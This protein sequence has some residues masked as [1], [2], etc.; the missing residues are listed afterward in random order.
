[1]QKMSESPYEMIQQ[2]GSMTIFY[3]GNERI[4]LKEALEKYTDE[5][6][7]I[8]DDSNAHKIIKTK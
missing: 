4:E 3:V 6:L 1:M 2:E 7:V 5:L 8:V